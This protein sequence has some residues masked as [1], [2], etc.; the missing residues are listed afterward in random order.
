MK[1]IFNTLTIALVAMLLSSCGLYN[2]YSRPE[3][4][5]ANA[6]KLYREV[7]GE[8]QDTTLNIANIA[9]REMFKDKHL[10]RLIDSALVRNTD[11]RIAN[12]RV[13]EAE[14][15]LKAARLAYVPSFGFA[16]NGAYSSF[17]LEKG[18]WTYSVPVTMSWQVD[19][20]GRLTN[21]KRRAK[22][23]YEG[24]QYYAQAVQS[25]VVAM[26]A[27]TYYTLVMLDAQLAIAEQT[28]KS[29]GENVATIELL[30]DGGMSNEA[31]VAQT[32][33]TYY[34]ICTMVNEL[35]EQVSLVE[36]SLSIM[37]ADVPQYIERGT[38]AEQSAP[39][40]LYVGI[41]LQL[42][43]NRPDVQYAETMLMQAHYGENEARA[44]LYPSLSLGGNAGWTNV[45]GS[46][47][48]NPGNLLLSA[49]ASLFQP[50]FQNGAIRARLKMA[51]LQHEQAALAFRQTV[52]NAGNEVNT[53]LEQCQT[54]RANRSLIAQQIEALHLA[55]ENTQLLMIH[56]SATYLEVLY[57]QQAL[58]NA[59]LG[60]AENKFSE[61]Q[62]VVNLYQALGGGRK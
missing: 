59:Q 36:N 32:K 31:A 19:I 13:G 10:Q 1:K 35:R 16:P 49:A 40:Q 23:A 11:L 55:V 30:K 27:N 18:A 38:L 56:G 2:K 50:I 14:A 52:L 45:V 7:K 61:L 57:A 24:S 53:A 60:E 39:E 54:S 62:G 34:S 26:V 42:L 17:A 21:A 22:A 51:K 8:V 41:P 47:I 4:A 15:A 43:S 37:L 9:W 6:E 46:A 25:R 48:I 12:L 58:L 28:A 44:A 5:T 3:S 20:F 29:W 33:A